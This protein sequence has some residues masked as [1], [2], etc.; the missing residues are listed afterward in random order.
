[1][2]LAHQ[3]CEFTEDELRARA[4]LAQGG[5]NPEQLEALA[6]QLGLDARRRQVRWEVLETLIL[7]QAY[8]IVYLDRL[9]LDGEFSVHAVIPTRLSRQFITFLDP[10][11]GERRVSIRKFEIGRNRVG[12]WAV[13]WRGAKVG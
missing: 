7:Q 3:G 8:P 1:M 10:L 11:R 13:I 9:P 6:T 5:L 12:R 4:D 2:I